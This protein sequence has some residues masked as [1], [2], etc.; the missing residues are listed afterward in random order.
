MH[1][2]SGIS[3]Y[4]RRYIRIIVHV[5]A[6]ETDVFFLFIG[7]YYCFTTV[8]VILSI[9]LSALVVK[10][11]RS[12]EE[13]NRPPRIIKIVCVLLA[14]QLTKLKKVY[15]TIAYIKNLD[16]KDR[17]WRLWE[18]EE[19]NVYVN[20]KKIFEGS[21]SKWKKLKCV[22]DDDIYVVYINLYLHDTK[23]YS[24]HYGTIR[25][26]TLWGQVIDPWTQTQG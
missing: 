20:A 12:G 11:G 19:Q 10:I 25:G 23:N 1:L 8:I 17:G 22:G 26:L 18:M 7:I 6:C 16:Y 5:L 2:P 9:F 24:P 21:K 3:V 4:V 14:A 13:G 15:P